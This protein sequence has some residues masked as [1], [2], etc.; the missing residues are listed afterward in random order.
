MVNAPVKKKSAGNFK[1]SGMRSFEAGEL[2]FNQGD[3][4]DSLYI[5]QKGQIRLFIPKGRGFVDLAI[6]R[7]GEVIGE[8]A[9]FD[10]KTTRRSCS[11]TAILNTEVI[12][13]SFKAFEK[14]MEGLNPWFK[15]IINTL[16]DRLRK[17]ND[18]V[19]ALENNSVG[20]GAG[21]KVADYKF[22]HSVDIIRILSMFYLV[23]KT[24]GA[25]EAGLY[26]LH[27][28]KLKF[29]MCDIFNIT[30]VKFEEFFHILVEEDFVNMLEDNE[31]KPKLVEVSNPEEFRTMMT[32]FNQQRELDDVKKLVISERC[33]I[34]LGAIVQQLDSLRVLED[35]FRVDVSSIL[36][37]FK[38]RNIIISNDDLRDAVTAD[39]CD[40]IIVG[41]MNKLSSTVN[42][43][44]LRLLYVPIRMLNAIE[45]CNKRKVG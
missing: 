35:S 33:Q 3:P 2:M 22:F 16:A 24:H 14:T 44:K 40:D 20:F 25:V 1:K 32:F 15:T 43:K 10:Q 31:G 37:D 30:E 45:K 13:I 29:Y 8:M 19:K 9:Y 21:G 11:A 34:F 41:E 28:N 39:I 6:L 38:D 4:A 18:K 23:I 17:T 5:I 42:V 27:Q 7:A 12:E 26:H 36:N